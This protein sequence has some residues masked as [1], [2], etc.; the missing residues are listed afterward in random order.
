MW[1]VY[2]ISN[3]RRIIIQYTKYQTVYRFGAGSCRIAT[4]EVERG[5]HDHVSLSALASGS[6]ALATRRL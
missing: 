4:A 6:I 1:S 5:K 3:V 2:R